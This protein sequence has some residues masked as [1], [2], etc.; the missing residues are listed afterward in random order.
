MSTPSPI[1]VTNVVGVEQMLHPERYNLNDYSA[2][3][4]GK[5]VTVYC[6]SGSTPGSERWA[7][8][9]AL[10]T[11]L[12]ELGFGIVTGGYCGSMEAVS[13]GAVVGANNRAGDAAAAGGYV[14]TQP[15]PFDKL[16]TCSGLRSTTHTVPARAPTAADVAVRGILVPGQFPDRVMGGNAFLSESID[17]RNLLHRLDILSSL[18]RYYV[19]LPGTLGT[20]TELMIIWSLSILHRKG[21][22]RPVVLCWRNPWEPVVRAAM[23]GLDVPVEQ[24]EA[25]RFVDS[26]EECVQI[27]DE[28]YKAAAAV[29]AA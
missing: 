24:L 4:C 29:P 2:A 20:L 10:G 16:A 27:I 17:A 11:S 26:V 19:V 8:A 28:D 1:T 22:E 18:T 15:T 7:T 14:T 5:H 12:A 25:L 13:K 23:Q 21:A 9:E 6:W 3:K